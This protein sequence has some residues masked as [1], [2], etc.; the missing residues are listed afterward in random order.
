MTFHFND[1][2]VEMYCVI[3]KPY[4]EQQEAA[5]LFSCSDWSSKDDSTNQRA[6]RAAASLQLSSKS[7]PSSVFWGIIIK[8][9]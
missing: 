2:T 7:V 1:V 4:A 9:I 6:T 3:I 5:W 8:N